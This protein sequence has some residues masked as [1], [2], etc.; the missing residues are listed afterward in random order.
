MEEKKEVKKKT[1]YVFVPGCT[2]PAYTPEGVEKVVRHLKDSLGDENV[3]AL[4]QC[5]GKVTKFIGEEAKFEERNKK[6]ID[7]LDEMGAEVIITVCPSCYKVFERT[8]KNQK[9]I[10]Y[11]DLMH[12]LIGIPEEAK[13]IGLN[14]DVVFNIH[15][16]CVTRNE[17]SHHESV[18][19]VLDQL[20][21][22]WEEIERNGKN[23]RCCGVGGMV[24]ASNPELYQRVY[25]RRAGDFNQDHI[26]TYCGSCRGTMQAA[27]KDAVHILD[28]IFGDTYTKDQAKP[29]GYRTEDEMWA[30][31]LETKHRLEQF[32]QK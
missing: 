8:A 20:G 2:V 9:V 4:L 31:R 27:G 22:K 18:R 7:I 32:E 30:N 11:W 10:A 6:A 29:R 19:W 3:G 14:S 24:C 15:D 21:Y 1:K 23:T 26:L 28:L 25:T 12:H 13:G 5:C 16:S 17:T